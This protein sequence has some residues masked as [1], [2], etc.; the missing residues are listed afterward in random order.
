MHACM[1]TRNIEG[2]R[3]RGWQKM[4][5]KHH[6]ING[7]ESEQILGHSEG[8]A[9]CAAVYGATKSQTRLSNSTTTA[10]NFVSHLK[11][12]YRERV[13]ILAST[14]SKLGL[15]PFSLYVDG[16]DGN[17]DIIGT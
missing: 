9:Y 7:H 2:K 16:L 6:Q 11:Y 3:R 10:T 5:G 8:G 17:K 1:H 15:H 14:P 12:P 4:V 13:R